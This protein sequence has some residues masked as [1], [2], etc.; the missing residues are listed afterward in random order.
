MGGRSGKFVVPHTEEKVADGPRKSNFR[1]FQETI[2]QI[3]ILD[4]DQSVQSSDGVTLENDHKE[5]RPEGEGNVEQQANGDVSASDIAQEADAKSSKKGNP[6]T[7]ILRRLSKKSISLK[8]HSTDKGA[9]EKPEDAQNEANQ[10]DNIDELQ[11]PV[12]TENIDLNPVSDNAVSLAADN[13]VQ[14]V[15]LSATN[16]HLEETQVS[17]TKPSENSTDHVHEITNHVQ[18]SPC[19]VENSHVSNVYAEEFYIK[20]EPVTECKMNSKEV[21]VNG[22]HSHDEIDELNANNTSVLNDDSLIQSKLA[23]L[24]LVNGHAEVNGFHCETANDSMV[25]ANNY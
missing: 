2:E 15:I 25:A 24:E 4:N 6:L 22:V 12:P 5:N 9:P 3:K 1:T 13:L 19:E 16:T 17:E 10:E 23:N 14:D 18:E 20:E 21:L 7:R 11:P 8:K